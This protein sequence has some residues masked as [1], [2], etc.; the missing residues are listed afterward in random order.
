MYCKFLQLPIN[1][2]LNFLKY[3][4]YIHIYLY[5]SFNNYSGFCKKSEYILNPLLHLTVRNIQT[6]VGWIHS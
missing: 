6:Q 3:L 5:S 1:F 2:V 4:R